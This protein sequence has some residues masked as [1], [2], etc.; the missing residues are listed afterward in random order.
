M[1]GIGVSVLCPAK[2]QVEHRGGRP[3]PPRQ[4]RQVRLC[5]RT[6]RRSRTLHSIYI[7][8]MEPV[9]LAG[10][11]KRGIEAN[12]LYIIPYPEAK[13]GLKK[14]FDAILDSVLPMEAD[15]EG[16]KKRVAALQAWAADRAR[17]FNKEQGKS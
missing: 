3:H 16:A 2:H 11:V 9:E 12:Q 14:H 1:M 10:H 13:E 15:P 8:G 17:V 6:R 4:I 5:P 7:H